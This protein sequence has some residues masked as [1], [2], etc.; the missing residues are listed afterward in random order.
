MANT[1]ALELMFS[2]RVELVLVVQ[3]LLAKEDRLLALDSHSLSF[4]QG[5]EIF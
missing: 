5:L 4:P 1:L 2:L 3:A